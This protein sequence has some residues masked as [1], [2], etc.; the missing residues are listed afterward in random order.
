M[1]G[2]IE[3]E[4]AAGY[5]TT[6]FRFDASSDALLEIARYLF[7]AFPD[8]VFIPTL[9]FRKKQVVQ[10]GW[11]RM[12]FPVPNSHIMIVHDRCLLEEY[13]MVGNLLF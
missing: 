11:H 8:S 1:M 2:L 10:L 6:Q 7:N 9:D 5:K 4:R 12:P 3:R 13:K